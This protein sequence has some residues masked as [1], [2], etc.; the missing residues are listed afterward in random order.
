MNSKVEKI[1]LE[2]KNQFPEVDTI[3]LFGSANE[4]G[5]TENSDVDLFFVD[6]KLD[7]GRI[8]KEIFSVPVEIQTDNFSNLAKDIEFERGKLLNRN[9]SNMISSAT[10]LRT[11][12]EEKVRDL[13]N[14]AKEVVE[15]KTVYSEEDVKMWKYSIFDYLGKAKK[16]AER[17]DTI[18]FYFDAHLVVQNVLELVLAQTGRYFPQPK[19]LSGVIYEISLELADLLENFFKEADF[20]V[21]I[22]ILEDIAGKV[23]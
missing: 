8:D 21:K 12:S 1:I 18:G 7:E 15:S 14:L 23:L 2:A 20:R 13:Q 6:D 5:W 9:V 19:R 11:K 3:L 17:G 4:E 22:G 16:D 10:I